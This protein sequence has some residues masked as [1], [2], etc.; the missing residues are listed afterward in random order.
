MGGGLGEGGEIP[1]REP[2]DLITN[3]GGLGAKIE[4]FFWVVFKRR[5]RGP[6]SAPKDSKIDPRSSKNASKRGPETLP[7]KGCPKSRIFIDF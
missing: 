7:K 5:F 2:A 1:K 3:L 4:P 6:Q